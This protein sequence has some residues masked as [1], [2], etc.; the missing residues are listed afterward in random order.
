MSEPKVEPPVEALADAVLE[1]GSEVERLR[2]L[3]RAVIV[4]GD[5]LTIIQCHWCG[6]KSPGHA[7]ECPWA[8]LV[9]EAKKV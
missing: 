4:A 2:G 6:A 9:A 5:E 7:R 8:A 1:R 3:I